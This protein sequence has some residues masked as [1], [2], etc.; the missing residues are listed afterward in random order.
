MTLVGTS[1]VA[2]CATEVAPNEVGKSTESESFDVVLNSL[3]VSC[4]DSQR[5][6]PVVELIRFDRP[7]AHAPDACRRDRDN[8]PD[9]HAPP[10][11]TG[12]LSSRDRVLARSSAGIS[13]NE[14]YVYGAADDTVAGEVLI[15]L[16][17]ALLLDAEQGIGIRVINHEHLIGRFELDYNAAEMKL[18]GSPADILL[19][20]VASS[21]SDSSGP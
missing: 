9:C 16:D 12:P 19:V 14:R 4:D 8:A 13:R 17:K 15:S 7:S 5:C 3:D 6:E 21:A 18:E 20:A 2:A 10:G 1:L 11:G